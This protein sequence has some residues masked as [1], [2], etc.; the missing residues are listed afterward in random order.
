WDEGVIIAGD[1]G[2][3]HT[4]IHGGRLEHYDGRNKIKY[5]PVRY[6]HY[7]PDKAFVYALLGREE[8]LCPVRYGILHSWLMDALYKSAKTKAPVKL[9]K[10]PLPAE[11]RRPARAASTALQDMTAAENIVSPC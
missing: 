6:P 10:P 8:P 1:K 4:G 2:R 7:S 5:P 9:T 11:T 3:I